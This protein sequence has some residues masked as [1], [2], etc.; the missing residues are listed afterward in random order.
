MKTTKNTTKAASSKSFRRT[1]KGDRIMSSN[2]KGKNKLLDT[3]GGLIKAARIKLNLRA[4]DIAAICYVTPECVFQWERR[5]Y[6]SDAKLPLIAQAYNIPFK[7]LKTVNEN[8]R[9]V[10]ARSAADQPYLV[11]RNGDRIDFRKADHSERIRRTSA[12]A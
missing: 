8:G 5:Y 4:E 1:A 6:V 7:R 9:R 11:D 2:R 3:V 10:Y 12:A